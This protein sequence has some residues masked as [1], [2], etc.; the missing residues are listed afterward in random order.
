MPDT[1]CVQL[2]RFWLTSVWKN[3]QDLVWKVAVLVHNVLCFMRELIRHGMNEEHA[4][5]LHVT[6][7]AWRDKAD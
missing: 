2:I 6:Q 5:L 1:I 4:Y 7:P 3:K